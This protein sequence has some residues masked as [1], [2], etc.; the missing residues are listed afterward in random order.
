[1]SR[2][3]DSV[4]RTLDMLGGQGFPAS[5]MPG[6]VSQE[7]DIQALA[8]L[9]KQEF[10]QFD[11]WIN[12]AGA[13]APYGPSVDIASDDFMRVLQTNIFGAY[14]GSQ[15][16]MR[17]FLPRRSG[18]LINI[19]GRG[20]RGPQPMQNAYASS[21]AWLKNFTLGLAKEYQESGVGVYLLNPGMMVTEMTQNVQVIQGYEER[22]E[23]FGNVLAM[24]A[25]DPDDSAE[26][27][28]WLASSATDGKTGL[29]VRQ[30]NARNM[31]GRLVRMVSGRLTGRY[32]QPPVEIEVTP[33]PT[34]RKH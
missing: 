29:F 17:E 11:I 9:A 10:G 15:V 22:L 27:A 18:K 8:A 3:P 2:S 31:L 23:N 6:D 5:G 26:K 13:S 33:I 24:L 1:N 7:A 16:A 4:G 21:K 28:V 25:V 14:Y 12:N 30:M 34:D 20:D 32:S 19:S